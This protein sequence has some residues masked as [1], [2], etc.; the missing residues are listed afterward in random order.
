M[1]PCWHPGESAHEGTAFCTWSEDDIAAFEAAYPLGSKYRLALARLVSMA[2]RC[3]D[4][5]W[6]GRGNARNGMLHITPSRRPGPRSRSQLLQRWPRQSTP[7]PR[8]STSR[9]C[10]TSAGRR[11]LPAR[12]ASGSL[13]GAGGSV[14]GTFSAH[15]LRKAACR[16]L[17]EAGCSTN[18]IAAISAH[19]SLR[20][21]ER[22]TRA[23]DQARTARNAMARTDQQH[24]LTNPVATIGKPGEKGR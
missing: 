17:A 18:E 6:V 7:R 16:R 22:Y 13:S 9:S 1:V 24:R 12:S 23:A 21:V 8:A 2:L 15:G 11:L 3:V 19:A 14:Y 10:S 4:V 5:V 20:E